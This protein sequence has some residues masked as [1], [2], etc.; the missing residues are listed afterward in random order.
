MFEE[1]PTTAG[2]FFSSFEIICLDHFKN[3]NSDN[4]DDNGHVTIF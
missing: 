2:F 3:F 4:N 1:V